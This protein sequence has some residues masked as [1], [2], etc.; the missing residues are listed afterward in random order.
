MK[1]LS[2][3]LRG[4]FAQITKL[5]SG[6]SK[7]YIQVAQLSDTPPTPKL[8]SILQGV[9]L[10]TFATQKRNQPVNSHTIRVKAK[11]KV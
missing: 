1:K 10:T 2:E 4:S 7:V 11:I 8:L 6:K 9:F 3:V 5:L